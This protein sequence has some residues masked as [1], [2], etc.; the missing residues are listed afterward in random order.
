MVTNRPKRPFIASAALPV[1]VFRKDSNHILLTADECKPIR[2]NWNHF[3]LNSFIFNIFKRI[4][5]GIILIGKIKLEYF[6]DS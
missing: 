5:I 6:K 3:N 2:L 1:F 4:L